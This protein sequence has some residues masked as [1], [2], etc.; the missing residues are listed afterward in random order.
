M[1]RIFRT[2]ALVAVVAAASAAPAAAQNVSFAAGTQYD[3]G[4]DT[5]GVAFADLN[6]DG[7]P[8]LIVAT[9]DN[10]T[11]RVRL[12]DG[13]GNFGAPADLPLPPGGAAFG[14][15][16]GDFNEDGHL[17]IATAD[18]SIV[19]YAAVFFGHGDGTFDAVSEFA[20]GS[21]PNMV[22]AADFNGDGHLDLATPDSSSYT[23][24][25]LRGNGH[26]GFSPAA[27][28][29]FVTGANPTAV[30][31][32]DLNGDH[33]LDLVVTNFNESTVSVFLGTGSGGFSALTPFVVDAPNAAG[34][35]DVGILDVDGNG[36]P[37]LVVAA[38]SENL[39]YVFNGNDGGDGFGDG[40][41]TPGT[42]LPT[43]TFPT[44]VNVS[45]VNGD[46]VLDVVVANFG[47]DSLSIYQGSGSFTGLG[48]P[49]TMATAA[50]SGPEALAVADVNGDG[51]PDL[52]V[53]YG[54]IDD[55]EVF[56]SD[57]CC[58][59]TVTI[60]GT[61]TGFVSS[62][63][64]RINCTPDCTRA[65]DSSYSPQL[66]A[67]PDVGSLFTGW[68]G[69]C[70]GTGSCSIP[71]GSDAVVTATFDHLDVSPP[72]FPTASV[73]TAVST[74]IS[75]TNGTAPY[76][77]VVADGS[78]PPGLTLADTGELTGT[79][80]Q[81]GTFAFSV[82]GQDAFGVY[83]TRDY[84]ITVSAGATFTIA[85]PA[86]LTYHDTAQATTLSA[87]VVNGAG[88][89][90]GTV[91]FTVRDAST[92]VIGS[93]VTS[94]P[95]SGGAA[96]ASY[97]LPAGTS[98]QP[99]TITA[100]YSGSAS[101]LASA[102][103]GPLIVVPAA[104]TT[105]AANATVSFSS[106]AQTVPLS[107]A[108]ASADGIVNGGTVT[109]TVRDAGSAVIGAPASATVSAGSATASYV[110]PAGTVPQT[111]TITAAFGG[112]TNFSLSSDA[113]HTL[114][115]APATSSTSPAPVSVVFSASAQAIPLSATVASAGGTVGSGTVTFTVRT[116]GLSTV[117]SSVAGAVSNGVA[118]AV[119]TLPGGTPVQ[120][121]TITASFGATATFTASAGSATLQVG[122]PS[123]VVGPPAPPIAWLGQPFS[124]PLNATGYGDAVFAI[125]GTLPSGLSLNGSAVAG[126]PTALGRFDVTA[127][128]TSAAAGGCSGTQAYT[129]RVMRAPL[130]ATG[131]G[132]GA[133]VNTFD[134]GG[135]LAH[136]ILAED[137]GF[138]GGIR[139]AMADLTGDGI[140][141]VIT[142]PGPGAAA[143]TVRVFDGA[144]GSQVGAF[145]AYPAGSPGGVLVA[146]G[147]VNGDGVPDIVTGR[148]GATPE[149]RVFD[150]RTRT[151]V[152]DFLAYDP[153][154]VHG[155]SVAVGDVDADGVAEIIT[156][157]GPGGPPEVDV[158]RADGTRILSFD[159]YDPA[160][161][162][163]VFVAAGDV[164]GDGRADIVTG[165]GPGGG[166][167]VRVFSGVDRH[168][169]H[170]FMAYPPSFTGG[171][172]V[173][174]SDLDLDGHAEIITGAGPGGAPHVRV[175]DG[176][177]GD[178]ITSLLAFDA[179]L[180]DGVFVAA[181][182]PQTRLFIDTPVA[183]AIVGPM[184]LVGGWAAAPGVTTA[185]GIDAI[186]VWALPVAGGAPIFLGAAT[187]GI[188][189]PDVGAAFGGSYADAGFGLIAGPLPSGTYAL[190]AFAH[191]ARSGTFTAAA[192]VRIVVP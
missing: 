146:V 147:D 49:I 166:P 97:T 86:I 144:S 187:T 44:S 129:F 134:R 150:G 32:G 182:A 72:S 117:G 128:A 26:G 149:V 89:N 63:P 10:G 184:F 19:G 179:S 59:V 141:E 11:V 90:A 83:G 137:A 62:F 167:H 132:S 50:S 133:L 154:L 151:L 162:G 84:S 27:G 189:R 131:A 140:D 156:G 77:F 8:D 139:V 168:E 38:Y 188:S 101:F 95:V 92:A 47:S 180:S 22:I 123:I 42:L 46:G 153:S 112:T 58:F 74:T 145:D 14:L 88:V 165:A 2:L 120:P 170:G 96:S 178:G 18:S 143:P 93:P 65:F 126:T 190:V 5:P 54:D 43:G 105:A 76:T 61:G 12:G 9:C 102:G 130:F 109:F 31:A 3:S 113:A 115:V 125:A 114:V 15:A 157:P 116:A 94:G 79:P 6:H 67:T 91:T 158:F 98:V 66:D 148:D 164:D 56:L 33:V 159:A 13:A 107:A 25:V 16:I 40:T 171:V 82:F 37:D 78:L 35:M 181:P 64:Q 68:S 118:S 122:C 36:I 55:S 73:G 57:T 185:S 69:A 48:S 87:T 4:S 127:T 45:D 104:S 75:T 161:V 39:L 20:V 172:R 52:V 155:V 80:T 21:F 192:I 176:A 163:G 174:A 60:A 138:T 108:I 29:P 169:I 160:F 191:N 106:A 119:Y 70:T 121:L 103:A 71:A 136:S 173:A 51:K 53:G 110:L 1:V 41:F 24:S 186:H 124:M 28:S 34:P 17:D 99:L 85:A 30:R 142:A 175:W 111:L 23:L 100:S 81:A 135:A 177:T 152:A 183:D 7:K